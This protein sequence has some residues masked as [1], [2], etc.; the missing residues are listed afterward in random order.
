MKALI[1][2]GGTK[3]DYEEIP[4]PAPSSQE[5][6]FDVELAGV[7]GSDL[8]AYRGHPGPRR[9]PLVLGHEAVGHVD[10]ERF[11]VYPLVG[12]GHCER[13]RAGED[14][15]CPEW[16]L[17]GM[18]RQGVF[19]QR[20]AVPRTSLFPVPTAMDSM[21]AVLTEPLACAVG[22]LSHHPVG[23]RSRVVVLGC[24]PI[25]LLSILLAGSRGAD[26]IAVDPLASRQ[27]LAERLGASRAVASAEELEPAAA[28]LVIDAAGFQDTW[29]AAL[30]LVAAAGDIV[31]VGLGDAEG[32]LGM[33]TLVRR[34]IRM[35]GQF[36]YSRAEFGEALAAL[37]R[38]EIDPAW[39]STEP[40]AEGARAFSHLVE[41]PENYVKVILAASA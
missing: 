36:A 7:C 11:V 38:L 33:A 16:R 37:D 9:P 10:G 22:A 31:I 17:I 13:C 35:R 19:A 8:H 14:N 18:H 23:P 1:W 2:K 29:Q 6:S 15:L 40:L 12:C 30:A 32:R 24:G 39:L 4:D 41:Q 34:A 20:V 27:G 21:T 5:V 3:M 28:D 25:G 26:V